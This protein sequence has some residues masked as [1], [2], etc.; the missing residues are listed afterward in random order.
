M[1]QNDSA[2]HGR[3]PQPRPACQARY[4]C[5][6]RYH[7]DFV[8]R[9]VTRVPN[10][11]RACCD[12]RSFTMACH[13]SIKLA[14]FATVVSLLVLGA[15]PRSSAHGIP[16]IAC[17]LIIGAT[18]VSNFQHI[19]RACANGTIV[20]NRGVSRII[21]AISLHPCVCVSR[22]AWPQVCWRRGK[23]TCR[24]WEVVRRQM[25]HGRA[26]A[27]ASHA[28]TAASGHAPAP[29]RLTLSPPLVV[30]CCRLSALGLWHR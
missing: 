1:S 21:T 25:P 9:G 23:C 8:G 20:A 29:T 27:L 24:A 5:Q 15:L 6:N 2:G 16:C 30:V 13:T 7:V 28:T 26:C 17:T 14:V 12:P 4:R 22:C 3:V 19:P 11:W 10:L 18:R